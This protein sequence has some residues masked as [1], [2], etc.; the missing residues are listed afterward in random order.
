[1]SEDPDQMVAAYALGIT[2]GISRNEI[3]SRLR[4]D[5]AL[6]VKAENWQSELAALDLA[7]PREA[8]PAGLLARIL[9]EI[10]TDQPELAGTVTRRAGSGVWTEM[11]PGVTYT[12]LFDDPVTKRRS[13]LIRALPGATFESHPHIQ[14]H[15][16]CI[17]LEGDLLIGDLRLGPGDY[18]FAAAGTSH[19][20]MKTVLGCLCFQTEPL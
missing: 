17:V 4:L 10:G 2:R 12:V 1:M 7:A 18:H 5:P 15:E 13:M 9:D 3:E 11:A 20:R 8:P 14:G 19:P 16:E 6:Q